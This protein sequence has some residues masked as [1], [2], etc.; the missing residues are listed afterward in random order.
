MSFWENI[1]FWLSK[2][3]AE[4][5]WGLSIFLLIAVVIGAIY[6]SAAFADWRERRKRK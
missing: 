6:T 4:L 3:V 5:V 2:Q 1:Q